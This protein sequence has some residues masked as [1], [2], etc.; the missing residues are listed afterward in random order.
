M[1]IWIYV[2]HVHQC[3]CRTWHMKPGDKNDKNKITKHH[4]CTFIVQRAS[5]SVYILTPGI[6]LLVKKQNIYVMHFITGKDCYRCYQQ[7]V[8]NIL[9]GICVS[10]NYIETC[11]AWHDKQWRILIWTQ[12]TV[13]LAKIMLIQKV[14]PSRQERNYH[15][16]IWAGN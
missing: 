8:M 13:W 4:D 12:T 6:L 11:N 16:P 14:Y 2:I 1:S 9:L 10:M 7:G 5:T 15:C 3:K